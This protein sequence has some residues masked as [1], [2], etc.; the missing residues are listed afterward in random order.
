[1]ATPGFFTITKRIQN[2]LYG[3][4]GDDGPLGSNERRHY[5]EEVLHA[6]ADEL[7]V[8]TSATPA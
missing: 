1:M 5:Y 2:R 6:N 7:H 8:W 3:T 4:S